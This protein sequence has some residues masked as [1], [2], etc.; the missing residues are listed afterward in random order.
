MLGFKERLTTL[1]PLTATNLGVN[2]TGTQYLPE[3]L[4]AE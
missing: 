3:I 4:N 2:P 1:H